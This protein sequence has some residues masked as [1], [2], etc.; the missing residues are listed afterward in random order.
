M[1]RVDQAR[2]TDDASW[3]DHLKKWSNCIGCSLCTNRTHVVLARGSIPCDVLF[4]GE[5][6]GPSEDVIG[7]PFVGP[8]GRLLDQMISLYISRHWKMAFT[9]LVACIPKSD[10][11]S[12]F[13]EPPKEAILACEKRLVEFVNICRP[14][15]VIL[16]GKLAQKRILGQADFGECEWLG[17]DFIEFGHIDHPAYLLRIK[18]EGKRELEIQ[19]AAVTIRDTVYR[20]VPF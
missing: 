18:D 10:D 12:K 9:N 3:T 17:G 4:I 6:P 16:V 14:R 15:A 11:G 2:R 19:R 20:L 7:S 13:A 1:P 5:A 8:A